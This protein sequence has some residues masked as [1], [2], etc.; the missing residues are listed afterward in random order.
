V[1]CLMFDDEDD[2]PKNPWDEEPSEGEEEED[3]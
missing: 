2:E 1:I 3:A